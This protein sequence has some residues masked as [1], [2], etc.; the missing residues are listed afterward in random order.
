MGSM[1]IKKHH[2]GI[3]GSVFSLTSAILEGIDRQFR[4][5]Y[6]YI[7]LIHVRPNFFLRLA[8]V[9]VVIGFCITKY[10]F[11]LHNTANFVLQVLQNSTNFVLQN[12]PKLVYHNDIFVLLNSLP[13]LNFVIPHLILLA[14]VGR[15]RGFD[16]PLVGQPTRI[17]ADQKRKIEELGLNFS[18]WV[19]E[20]MDADPVFSDGSPENIA[21]LRE[22]EEAARLAREQAEK[23]FKEKEEKEKAEAERIRRKEEEIMKELERS[24]RDSR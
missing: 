23:R 9:S 10:D 2:N 4:N 14:G 22:K 19:R 17:R 13:K 12:T 3:S 16:E 6:S 15:P 21:K 7:Y 11:V 5:T 8:E 18:K 1:K 24:N 20:A